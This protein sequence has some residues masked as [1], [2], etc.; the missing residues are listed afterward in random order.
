MANDLVSIIMLSRND[1]AHVEESVRSILAQT[2]TNW[3][4]LFVDDN[5]NDGTITKMMELTGND[6]RFNIT[7]S[8]YDKGSS[9]LRNKALKEAR[10]R[11]IA[12]LDAGDTWTPDKLE[13]QI[14][15]ME[16]NGY[17]FSYTKYGIMDQES[18]DRGV[19]VGGKAHVNYKEMRKCCWP[20]YLTLPDG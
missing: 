5:S 16:E 12:F 1:V 9:Y 7:Q 15:F 11:W 17:A 18:Q 3:E 8:V 4:L 6:P 10:G 2:Y 20:C 14:R 13:K 19:V